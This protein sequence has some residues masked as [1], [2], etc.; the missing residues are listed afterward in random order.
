MAKTPGTERKPA[1]GSTGS[2]IPRRRRLK[3][4]VACDLCRLRKVKCDGVRPACGN[5]LKRVALVEPCHYSLNPSNSGPNVSQEDPFSTCQTL[6]DFSRVAVVNTSHSS[7]DGSINSGPDI[8]RLPQPTPVI[9]SPL[10]RLPAPGSQALHVEVDSMTAVGEG[11]NT[12]EYFGSS[13]AGSFTSQ[14][15]IAIDARLGLTTANNASHILCQALAPGQRQSY[16]QQATTKEIDYSLPPRRQ[17]DGLLEIY[18]R[19]VDTLYPFLERESFE[20]SYHGIFNGTPIQTD[21]R[22][23][24]ATLN[25]VLALSTQLQETLGTEQREQTCRTFFSRAQ[26]LVRL[27]IWDIGSIELLQYL[28]LLSQYLQSITNPHQT[29]MVVGTAIRI[30]QGLGLHLPQTSVGLK[31]EKVKGLVQRLWHGCV[32]MDRMTSVT[33]GRPTMISGHDI[34]PTLGSQDIGT[35]WVSRRDAAG[36]QGK[37]H[38]DPSAFLINSLELYEIINQIMRAFYTSDPTISESP[39]SSHCGPASMMTTD[40]ITVLT[41]DDA[42]NRLEKNLPLYLKLTCPNISEDEIL[43]RKAVILQ[44]R[45]LHAR[46]L[47]LRPILARFCLSQSQKD[48]SCDKESL[49]D[50]M[51]EQCAHACVVSAQKM[52][53]IISEHESVGRSITLLPAWWYRV[54]YIYT[55]ATILLAAELRIA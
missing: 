31:N 43:H 4:A 9:S 1:D 32:L 25:V 54:Y 50:R 22:I 29:W 47:L 35:L 41:L 38:I 18:W 36:S 37:I 20:S 42:L 24:M 16:H 55:A 51:M 40:L 46:M 49:G 14:I 33:H 30:A 45:F 23:F 12:R 28:L 48:R 34:S 6:S 2:S 7:S 17:A 53:S 19:Y 11:G 39:S 13:S 3:I 26:S 52:I 15:R 21:E 10:Q 5:C 44:I 8:R 27:D